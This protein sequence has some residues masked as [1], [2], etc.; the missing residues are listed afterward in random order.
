MHRVLVFIY[1]VTKGITL[2]TI[3]AKSICKG[4]DIKTSTCRPCGR[5]KTFSWR[6]KDM[7]QNPRV[8]MCHNCCVCIFNGVLVYVNCSL[9]FAL[10]IQLLDLIFLLYA[11]KY[12]GAIRIIPRHLLN[13]SKIEV[14]IEEVCNPRFGGVWVT[15]IRFINVEKGNASFALPNLIF[16]SL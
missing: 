15:L 8:L 1:D 9:I 3:L 5:I 4:C 6:E 11:T 2:G 16:I 14:F 7:V 10:G 13:L 12:G